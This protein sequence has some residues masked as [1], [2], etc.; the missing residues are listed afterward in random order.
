[1]CICILARMSYLHP[2][3][4]A[5]LCHRTGLG[6][7]REPLP[8]PPPS[9]RS[10]GTP[11]TASPT[12]PTPPW[13]G[14]G[15]TRPARSASTSSGRWTDWWERK[16]PGLRWR[17]SPIWGAMASCTWRTSPVWGDMA[18]CTRWT[19]P[20]PARHGTVQD[21]PALC[22]HSAALALKPPTYQVMN[23][24]ANKNGCT[25]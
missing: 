12:L 7:W 2:S 11:T 3:E 10:P 15:S 8:G 18:S 25:Q 9:T 6:S 5:N 14:I 21:L 13:R 22:H 1:M 16:L 17:T 19:G 23:V 4:A 24:Q 20:G